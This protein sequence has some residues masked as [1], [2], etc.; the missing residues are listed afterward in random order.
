MDRSTPEMLQWG[1]SGA[2]APGGVAKGAP[3][4]Q[5]ACH[6]P[7][8]AYVA[9]LDPAQHGACWVG[10]NTNDRGYWLTLW[11]CQCKHVMASASL[12]KSVYKTYYSELPTHKVHGARNCAAYTLVQLF[13]K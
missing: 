8:A 5:E 7:F 2:L 3:V 6:E 4:I 10:S 13:G 9:V 1:G 11:A 12:Y